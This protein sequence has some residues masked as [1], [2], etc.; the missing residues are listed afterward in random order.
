MGRSIWRNKGRNGWE[1]PFL[2]MAGQIDKR[3]KDS[4]LEKDTVCSQ[5]VTRFVTRF[6]RMERPWTK[7]HS[8]VQIL[9]RASFVCA[10]LDL[11]GPPCD[12]SRDIAVSIPKSVLRIVHHGTGLE[13]LRPWA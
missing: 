9:G 5:D 13:D 8:L 11:P 2:G 6:V 1:P 3:E 12:R 7:G 10:K 4:F